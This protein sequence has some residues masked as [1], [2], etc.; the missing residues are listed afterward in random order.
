[1]KEVLQNQGSDGSFTY[2]D[3]SDASGHN[4]SPDLRPY[5]LTAKFI[6]Q[7]THTTSGG[8]VDTLDFTISED[9]SG[10]ISIR[11]FSI[12]NIHGALGDGGQ[13]FKTIAFLGE[14]LANTKGLTCEKLNIVYGCGK[15]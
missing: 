2:S 11:T 3:S 9:D 6:F 4:P 13:N 12:S 15:K 7:G 5:N 1:M 10:S 14:E 8:Y